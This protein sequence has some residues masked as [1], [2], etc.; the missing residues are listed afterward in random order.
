M[1]H[2]YARFSHM[3]RT[4]TPGFHVGAARIGLGKAL[5]T[6][7][8]VLFVPRTTFAYNFYSIRAAAV[9]LI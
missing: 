1:P 6:P 4:N 5:N 9:K 7:G 8:L 2:K 3:C